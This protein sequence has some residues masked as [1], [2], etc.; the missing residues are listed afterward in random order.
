MTLDEILHQRLADW[1]PP[2]GRHGLTVPDESRGWTVTVTAD[3]CDELGCLVW[4]MNVGRAAGAAA[5]GVDL[6]AWAQLIAN[7][8]TGLLEPLK[9]VEIDAARNEALLRSTTAARRG[10]K[11]FYYEVLLT[12]TRAAQVCRYQA[13]Q[14]GTGR[15]EQVAF[16]L[17][18]EALAKLA[19]DLTAD[20]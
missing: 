4:A 15:R 20:R 5:R 14:G 11:L 7:R 6:T 12:G 2:E 1:R 8:A 9:V 18:H 17:T 16:A 10:D 13:E 3:R 19:A